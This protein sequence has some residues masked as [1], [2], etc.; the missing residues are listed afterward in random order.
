MLFIMCNSEGKAKSRLQ[1]ETED[2]FSTKVQSLP[3]FRLACL[4]VPAIRGSAPAPRACLLAGERLRWH[5]CV[6]FWGD[7]SVSPSGVQE[8]HWGGAG[9]QQE[10]WMSL[11]SWIPAAFPEKCWVV[12]FWISGRSAADAGG[13]IREYLCRTA[14][15]IRVCLQSAPDWRFSPS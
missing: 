4:C 12:E 3:F 10:V 11:C 2:F 7:I 8:P 6:P 15:L 5:P 9:W 13:R 1:K 14:P